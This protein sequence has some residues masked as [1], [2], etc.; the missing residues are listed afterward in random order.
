MF[1]EQEPE[2]MY[3][4][5]RS[6]ELYASDDGGDSWARLDVR[7]PPDITYMKCVRA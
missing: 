6:G 5:L 4:G 3:I 1:D 7:V 2:N